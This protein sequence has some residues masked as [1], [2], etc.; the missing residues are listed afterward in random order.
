MVGQQSPDA[1]EYHVQLLGGRVVNGA[2]RSG[3]PAGPAPD[4]PLLGTPASSRWADL[5]N[6]F[7]LIR[8]MTVL[9][10]ARF[11]IQLLAGA[12]TFPYVPLVALAY[13]STS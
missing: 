9:P 13:R 5:G 6:S 8:N 7:G 12:A 2:R 10:I 1:F 4:E 11:Q 3:L